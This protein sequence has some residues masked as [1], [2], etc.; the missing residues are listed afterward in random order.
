MLIGTRTLHVGVPITPLNLILLIMDDV[1]RSSRSL[2]FEG[3][4]FK[5]R[6]EL[7]HTSQPKTYRKS[8]IGMLTWLT[9]D[10][11]LHGAVKYKVG[12]PF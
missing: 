1:K 4:I 2:L 11:E 7:R 12:H 8:N 3:I 6:V 9:F 10:I 5:K